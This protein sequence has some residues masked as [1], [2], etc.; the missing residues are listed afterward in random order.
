MDNFETAVERDGKHKGYI[1]AISFTRGAYE[2]AARAKT[3]KGIEIE[4]VPVDKLLTDASSLITPQQSDLFGAPTDMP[5]PRGRPA[6]DLPPVSQLVQS[7][8]ADSN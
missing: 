3:A 6:A 1:V 7:D 2:E 5:L 8:S 4:L